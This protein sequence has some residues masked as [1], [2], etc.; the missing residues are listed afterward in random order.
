M[1]EKLSF[2][3]WCIVCLF[4]LLAPFILILSFA[5]AQDFEDSEG[6]SVPEE[7]VHPD[8]GEAG[9]WIPRW[10]EREHL[11]DNHKLNVCLKD[12][13]LSDLNLLA[14]S[15]KNV[16][17]EASLHEVEMSRDDLMT[18]LYAQ[19]QEQVIEEGKA[20]RRWRAIW[21]LLGTTVALSAVA[22][23]LAAH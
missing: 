21:G 8:T 19:E 9:T 23:G 2:V 18:E 6:F 15:D 17:L 14:L 1:K 11:L 22:L 13:E 20:K 5:S 3:F 16:S 10:V 12:V 7:M 4:V